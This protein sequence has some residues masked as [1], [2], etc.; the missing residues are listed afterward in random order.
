VI[1][2]ATLSD[3]PAI[4]A[5]IGESVNGLQADDYDAEQR[6]GA[7]GTVFGV[8]R[9]MI[10]DGTYFVVEL[11]GRIVACGGWSRRT[12]PFGGDRSPR[13]DDSFLDPARDAARV[14]AFFVHPAFARR[15]L[16]SLLLEAC[17][18]AARGAGFRR[19]ELTSTL[20]GIPLYAARGFEARERLELVLQNGARLPVLRMEKDL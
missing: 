12:T 10:G 17:E 9:R 3:A 7:L 14:R 8:D 19:V 4:E 11:E 15:G 13:K 1:R 2:T 16:G 20:T 5:L 18:S 6:A